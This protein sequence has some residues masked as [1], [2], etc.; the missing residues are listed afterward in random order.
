M[1]F[2][3][4]FSALEKNIS[5][6]IANEPLMEKLNTNGFIDGDALQAVGGLKAQVSQ[7]L[8]HVE[9]IQRCFDN[10]PTAAPS[11]QPNI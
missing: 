7:I 10:L 5:K 6:L 3:F 9:S 11:P 1:T 8:F 2:F 4:I